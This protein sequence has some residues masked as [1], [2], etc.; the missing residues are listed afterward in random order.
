ML[1]S[2]IVVYSKRGNLPLSELSFQPNRISELFSQGLLFI[3][4]EKTGLVKH[5]CFA[6]IADVY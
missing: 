4:K 5:L 6:V 1:H 2:E 3:Q